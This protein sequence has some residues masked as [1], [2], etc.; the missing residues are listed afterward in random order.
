MSDHSTR[1]RT[2]AAVPLEFEHADRMS[3]AG[4]RK[5]AIDEEGTAQAEIQR[6]TGAW[7]GRG[8]MHAVLRAQISLWPLTASTAP[9]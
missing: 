7:L 5:Y 8:R 9:G 1:T 4:R 3:S 2:R 6:S